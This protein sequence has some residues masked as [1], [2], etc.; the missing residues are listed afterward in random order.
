MLEIFEYAHEMIEK[1]VRE[2]VR[3]EAREAREEAKVETTREMVLKVLEVSVGLVP[4][5]IADEVM[6]VSRPD[7]LKSLV[8]Q[9]V[10]CRDIEDF[11]KLLK[12]ANRQPAG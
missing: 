1:E 7:I 11:E 4:A 5:Y 2:K 8:G 12:L 9:A 6:S 3:E 10:K